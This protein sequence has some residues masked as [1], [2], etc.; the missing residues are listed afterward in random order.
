M[1]SFS[2][3]LRPALSGLR[4]LT[5]AGVFCALAAPAAL[6]D[7]QVTTRTADGYSVDI[8]THFDRLPMS[9]FSLAYGALRLPDGTEGG[10][11]FGMGAVSPETQ[12][13]IVQ[14]LE[15]EGGEIIGPDTVVINDM[16]FTQRQYAATGFLG[17]FQGYLLFADE[18]RGDGTVLRVTILH[19]NLDD[20]AMEMRNR[21]LLGSL[22]RAAGADAAEAD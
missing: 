18:P 3:P 21:Q 4:T 12:A 13:D 19:L 5:L 2:T 9:D 14:N 20:S 16:S 1:F 7:E 11:I 17:E 8:P 10:T 22:Q 15:R 6:A